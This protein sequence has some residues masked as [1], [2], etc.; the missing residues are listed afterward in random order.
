MRLPD[1]LPPGR[2]IHVR[3]PRYRRARWQ[4]KGSGAISGSAIVPPSG[5]QPAPTGGVPARGLADAASAWWV[6][7]VAEAAN[8][9]LRGKFNNILAATLTANAAS[10]T[11]TD[12]RISA[13]SAL[14]F[15][16]LTANAAAEMGAGTLYISALTNGGA[17]LAHANNSQAD[18]SFYVV[19]MG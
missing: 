19:I 4:S 5:F 3:F 11:L 14:L 2:G 8:N 16:P 1:P 9:M 6:R 17:T 15:S 18:R 12:V 10:T 7:Q 13:T